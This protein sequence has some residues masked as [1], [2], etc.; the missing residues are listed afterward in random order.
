M[1]VFADAVGLRIARFGTGMFDAVH[2]KVKLVIVCF[3][4]AAAFRFLVG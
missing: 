4:V 3:Q 1:E 2:V